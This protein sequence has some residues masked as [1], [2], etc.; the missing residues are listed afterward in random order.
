MIRLAVT[1]Q[2]I[3]SMWVILLGALL[4]LIFLIWKEINRKNRFLA[5]RIIAVVLM[6]GSITLWLLQPMAS[7]LKDSTSIILL[8]KNYDRAKVDSLSRKYPTYKLLRTQDAVAYKDVSELKPYALVDHENDISFI[9]GDGLPYYEQENISS[10][11]SFLPGKLPLGVTQLNAPNSVQVNQ[12]AT[13]SG[14]VNIKGSTTLVLEEPS[15]PKDSVVLQGTGEKSFSLSFQAHQPGLFSYSII[16]RDSI[17]S[18]TEGQLPIEV[19][20]EKKLNILIVQKYPSA[21]VRYL[22]NFLAEKG[23][24]L[25]VRSQISKNDF[26]YEF[27]KREA[28][29]INRFTTETLNEFDLVLIDSESLYGFSASELK[30]IEQSSKEGLGVIVLMNE[31]DFK[32]KLPLLNISFMQ[33]PKDTVHLS[34]SKQRLVL[35]A[36]AA[37][38][39]SSSAIT[40]L[41]TSATR[42]LS[43]YRNEVGG[44]IGFQLLHETYR[45]LLEGKENEYAALWSPLL[46]TVARLAPQSFKIKINNTFPYYQDEPLSIS[47]LAGAEDPELKS[48]STMLPLQEDVLIDN[49][50]HAST[51][52]GKSGWHSLTTQ[53]TTTLHYYVS[54]EYEWNA[55]RT[56]Q[57][58]QQH[59]S[60]SSSSIAKNESTL[61]IEHKLI[62]SL[63]IFMVFLLASGFLWLAPKL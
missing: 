9:L 58:Q 2:S 52:A 47:V 55:L 44:K 23:H 4:F 24:A 11:Y 14:V 50:W 36:L 21:E 63:W 45:L 41:T 43:G 28:A 39:Q 7:V 10:Y 40:P 57:Q 42:I 8:T 33:Y 54:P 62:S 17:A 20:P 49:Y 18:K 48:N 59:Q 12:T 26:H 27:S 16:L 13:L 61:T 25:I 5:F 1:F 46:E 37:S 22:K 53:D 31:V 34:V 29:R 35:P 30:S 19:T 51:W 15:G 60:N 38:V 32:K 56:A 3:F 6:I